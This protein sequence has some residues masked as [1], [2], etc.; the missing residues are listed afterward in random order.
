MKIRLDCL[1]SR[2]FPGHSFTVGGNR[3]DGA[4]YQGAPPDPSASTKV[5]WVPVTD[6][7]KLIDKGQLTDGPSLLGL[8]LALA[9]RHR[10]GSGA[11]DLDRPIVHRVVDRGASAYWSGSLRSRAYS[12][13]SRQRPPR[14]ARPRMVPSRRNPA[15][16]NARCSPTF[17][18]SVTACSRFA[19]VVVNK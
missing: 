2:S 18:L 13:Q 11:S 5:E 14:K 4:T 15:R 7:R 12:T 17:S 6:L 8:S 19:S 1:P 16:S 3:A 10:P 9:L